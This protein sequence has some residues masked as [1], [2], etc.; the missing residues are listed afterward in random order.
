MGA[1]VSR[2]ASILV[3]GLLTGSLQN[4]LVAQPSPPKP[5]SADEDF[6]V[7]TDA[8]RLL[9]TKSR[10]RLLQ[11]E[12]ERMSVRWQQFD[13]MVVAGAPMP[14]T[15][16][17]QGIYYRVS[18]TGEAGRKAVSWALDEKTDASQNLRQLALIFDWCGPVMTPSQSDRLAAKI[19]KAIGSPGQDVSRQS[20][21]ALAAIAIADHL[22]DQGESILKPIVEQWFRGQF[23]K[24]IEAGQPPMPREQTYALVELF[25]AIRDNLN[26]DL[27]ESSQL[28][29]RQFPL[30]YLLGHYPSPFPGPQNNYFIPIYVHDGEP[31]LAEAA[32]SRAAGLAMVAFDSN[33]GETQYLQGW[34]MQDRFM[35]RDPLGV[36]YEF[37]WANPYQPGLSYS[38]LPLVFHDGATGHV[39]ARASWDE[40][41]DWIAY[42]DGNLQLFRDGKLQALRSGAA[43]KPLRIGG[44]VLM[45]APPPAADGT[46]RLQ[47][48]TEATFILG[49][50]PRSTYDVEIDDEE[51][52][53]AETD[54]GGT[55]VIALP[56]ETQTGVRI[57]ERN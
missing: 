22:K 9:L 44:T 11:R 29:F 26:I 33:A 21:R 43:V 46:L 4:A 5:A 17:A 38:L 36:V 25:H 42:F 56:A 32:M 57:R 7:F 6:H 50:K 14:E 37:L 30:D 1:K 41:A 40:D 53:D 20:A 15:G 13:A 31:D 24:R 47:A 19:E 55:L 45:T 18:G 35:M 2:K 52:T 48:D 49:L 23:V 27:R 3:L 54:A 39:F 51:L 34:L 10:L 16:L 8:P 12:R 28:Y